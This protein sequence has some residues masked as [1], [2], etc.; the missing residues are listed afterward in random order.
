MEGKDLICPCFNLYIDELQTLI[1][2]HQLKK[3]NWVEEL[4]Y[5]GSACGY[6][7][8]QIIKLM[9]QENDHHQQA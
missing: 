5:A 6:C 3:F 8:P 7:I 2:V 1:R 9:V 4:T